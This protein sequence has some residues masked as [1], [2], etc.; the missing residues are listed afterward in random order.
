MADM[1]Q[2]GAEWLGEKLLA[3]ASHMVTYVRGEERLTL[4]A[5]FG[6]TALGS[7]EDLGLR[8]GYLDRDFLI[9]SG[10][11]ILG[12][13][14][15]LPTDGDRIEELVEGKKLVFEVMTPEGGERPFS[16]SDAT[17]SRMRIHTK[18]VGIE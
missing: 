4:S 16:Y 5:T 7:A 3:H 12:G 9:E 1:L 14:H 18:L 6:R 15:A 2:R 10:H 11:L 13:L 17:W 8:V